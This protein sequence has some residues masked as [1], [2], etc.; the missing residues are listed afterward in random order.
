M[1]KTEV[2]LPETTSVHTIEPR[3]MW[4]ESYRDCCVMCVGG[5]DE[6]EAHNTPVDG[7]GRCESCYGQCIHCG[8]GVAS[9]LMDGARTCRACAMDEIECGIEDA[10]SPELIAA[11]QRD[12]LA[13]QA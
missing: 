6:R 7:A 9:F 2:T 4:E 10:V 12:L 13:V 3:P 11:L 8:S 1:N 5:Y